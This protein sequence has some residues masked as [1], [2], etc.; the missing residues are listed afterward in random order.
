MG[1]V[2]TGANANKDYFVFMRNCSIFR[3]KVSEPGNYLNLANSYPTGIITDIL[4]TPRGVYAFW[5]QQGSTG[6]AVPCKMFYTARNLDAGQ[7]SLDYGTA[8][9]NPERITFTANNAGAVNFYDRKFPALVDNHAIVWASKQADGKTG[10]YVKD[11]EDLIPLVTSAVT[12][13]DYLPGTCA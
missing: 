13:A 12:P 6:T 3:Y 10:I 9:I 8:N 7:E 11:Y 4:E 1:I 2:A 5:Q